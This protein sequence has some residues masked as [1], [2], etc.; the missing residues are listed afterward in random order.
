MST[1]FDSAIKLLIR[2]IGSTCLITL[3][4]R[5]P[6]TKWPKP[7]RSN[8]RTCRALRQ[9]L[10]AIVKIARMLHVARTKVEEAGEATS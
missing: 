2:P 6:E 4:K 9:L 10:I 8:P 7:F 5:A 1:G 3:V